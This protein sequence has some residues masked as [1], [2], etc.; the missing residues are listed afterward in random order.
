MKRFAVVLLVTLVVAVPVWA[1][2]VNTFSR[3]GTDFSR[4]S[5]YA[6]TV[7]EPD[8]EK[9]PDGRAKKV[10]LKVREVARET[11][12]G[13]GLNETDPD[14]AD[15]HLTYAGSL[16]AGAYG[17]RWEG[18][19]HL[20][21]ITLGSVKSYAQGTVVLELLDPETRDVLWRGAADPGF[22]E[23]QKPEQTMKKIE[24]AVKK[25][26]RSYPPKK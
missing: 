26:L 24:K 8:P 3:E 19:G 14:K 18:T 22:R 2:K 13:Q 5:T 25:I 16:Y 6:L 4:F 10:W 12:E 7:P 15:L 23:L 9:D 1:M 21:G 17:A 11:L 20:Y